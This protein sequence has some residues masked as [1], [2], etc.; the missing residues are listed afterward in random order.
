MAVKR[1]V[2][3]TLDEDL[4]VA[5]EGVGNVSAQLNDAGWNLVEHRRRAER[6]AALLE[7]FDHT[8]G[9]L[10]DDPAEEVRLERLLGGTA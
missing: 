2:T 9:P 1:K 10:P 5:L 8:D 3:V 4:M 6:L 7:H